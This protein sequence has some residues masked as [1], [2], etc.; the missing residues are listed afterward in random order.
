M[1]GGEKESDHLPSVSV[2]GNKDRSLAALG[3][4]TF[5]LWPLLPPSSLTHWLRIPTLRRGTY[6]SF[7]GNIPIF[8]N[9]L[10]EN[11]FL[12]FKAQTQNLA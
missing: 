1:G 7:F 8:Y 12:L 11:S 10:E 3:S 9:M 5:F 2:I 4:I 6:F